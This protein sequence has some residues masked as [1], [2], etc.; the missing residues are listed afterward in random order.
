MFHLNLPFK[1]VF[2]GE[3]VVISFT[4]D[5]G[6]HGGND[7]R[8]QHNTIKQMRYFIWKWHEI[9]WLCRGKVLLPLSD[10]YISNVHYDPM[11]QLRTMVLSICVKWSMTCIITIIGA[12]L[13]FARHR[14]FS[15]VDCGDENG[16]SIMDLS[17]MWLLKPLTRNTTW[18]LPSPIITKYDFNTKPLTLLSPS[19]SAAGLWKP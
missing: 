17:N 18:F 15:F 16:H 7:L 4:F 3:R 8:Q 6:Y 11:S 2:N 5:S 9:T 14:E 13:A 19:K 12:P 1:Y 10:V